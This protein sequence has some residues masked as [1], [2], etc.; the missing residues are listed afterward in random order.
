MGEGAVLLGTQHRGTVV[1]T[2]SQGRRDRSH[3]NGI[4]TPRRTYVDRG[5]SPKRMAMPSAAAAAP[6]ARST[7]TALRRYLHHPGLRLGTQLGAG[8]SEAP[9]FAG[10]VLAGRGING[11]SAYSV[12]LTPQSADSLSEKVLQVNLSMSR[13][14]DS[15]GRE[16]NVEAFAKE[17]VIQWATLTAFVRSIAHRSRRYC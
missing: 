1:R 17:P 15:S 6:A 7:C 2:P 13:N 16:R 5:S 10:H 3:A 14:L 9:S 8:A 11:S 4:V 12:T